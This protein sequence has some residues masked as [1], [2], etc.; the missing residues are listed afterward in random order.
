LGGERGLS[1]LAPLS[2]DLTFQLDSVDILKQ[3]TSTAAKTVI[4]EML[5]CPWAEIEY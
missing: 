4:P 1:P 5:N 3:H 2:P